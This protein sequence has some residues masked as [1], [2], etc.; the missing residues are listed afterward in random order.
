ML[1]RSLRKAEASQTAWAFFLGFSP[2]VLL[3]CKKNL[4]F[5]KSERVTTAIKFTYKRR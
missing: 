2:K 4:R 1:G 5:L 3:N